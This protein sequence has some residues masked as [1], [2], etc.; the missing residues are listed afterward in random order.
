MSE[1]VF[2][3][4]ILK[5]EETMNTVEKE[6]AYYYLECFDFPEDYYDKLDDD[7]RNRVRQYIVLLRVFCD[8][9]D[10]TSV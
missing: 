2:V 6:I 9:S 1:H 3:D 4:E 10:T 5:Y 8:Y 7:G